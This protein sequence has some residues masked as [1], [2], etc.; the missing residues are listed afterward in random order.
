[1]NNLT[2]IKTEEV[3]R[4]AG[5]FNIE[6]AAALLGLEPRRFRYLLEAGLV[7]RPSVAIGNK[8]RRYYGTTDL[9]RIR[10]RLQDSE[11]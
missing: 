7:A 1:M 6:E 11:E 2:R 9:I 4:L 10:R 5:L 3:R 8:P